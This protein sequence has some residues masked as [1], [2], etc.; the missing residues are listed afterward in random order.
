MIKNGFIYRKIR[1]CGIPIKRNVFRLFAIPKNTK[2]IL[3]IEKRIKNRLSDG[4]KVNVFFILQY[5]EMWNSFKTVFDAFSSDIRFNAVILAVPKQNGVN[6]SNG[7]FEEKNE[8]AD[9]CYSND[10]PFIDSRTNNGW[11]NI[12]DLEPDIIFVQR[13]YDECMPKDYSLNKMST[14]A[15][16]CYIPYGFEFVRNVHLE[17]EYNDNFLNNVFCCFADNSETANFIRNRSKLDYYLGL[18]KIFDIGYPR[19]DLINQIGKNINSRSTVLWTPRWSTDE[20]NDRSFFFDYIEV[21][22]RYF[23]NNPKLNLIIRP[24]P[25]M[26]KNFIEKGVLTDIEVEHIKEGINN[27]ENIKWDNNINYLDSF[28]E[29]DILVSDFSSLIIEYFATNK[30]IIYCGEVD[31]FNNVGKQMA[32]G[33]YCAHNSE[34][35]INYLDYLTCNY[36]KYYDLNQTTINKYIKRVDNIGLQIKNCMIERFLKIQ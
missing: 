31:G 27:I 4:N 35:L 21:L 30:P 14:V 23:V 34:S 12:K 6:F 10:L 11:V 33:I 15:I 24:H 5:P 2:R 18:R 9:Y 19:F 32:R 20:I 29:S 28:N 3:L 7:S 26:F 22:K 16:L 8:A 25:L 13:P 17:I 36:D 1:R